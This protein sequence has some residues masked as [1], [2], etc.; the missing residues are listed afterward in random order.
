[1]RDVL[2]SAGLDLPPP[3]FGAARALEYMRVDKKVKGGRIRLIL[4][5]QLGQGVFTA[6]YPDDALMRT[7]ST[8]FG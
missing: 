8:H 7:L 4:L 5:Q 6:D 1:V 2:R 3:R